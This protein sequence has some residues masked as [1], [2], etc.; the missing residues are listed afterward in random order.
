M[1]NITIKEFVNDLASNKPIGGGCGCA[2]VA[3]LAAALGQMVGSLT[4]NKKKYINNK[5]ELTELMNETSELINILLQAIED[6]QKALYPLLQ[7]YKISKEDKSR[8]QTIQNA[9]KQ[10][11]LSPYNL[12]LNITKVIDLLQKYSQLGSPIALS[13]AATGAMLAHGALYGTAI[14]VKV[15]TTNIKDDEF[16]NITEKQI[17]YLLDIYSNKAINIYNTVSERIC[18]D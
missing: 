14:N 16:K 7:A 11:A 1:N 8:E 9:L 3:A 13:D 5:Q 6:D 17:N 15:N 4:I 10:A 2:L 12:F 18:H